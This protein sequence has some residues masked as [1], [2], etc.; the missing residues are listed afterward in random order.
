M[1]IFLNS[2][3]IMRQAAAA[4]AADTQRD[5]VQELVEVPVTQMMQQS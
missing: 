5:L 2:I 3:T 4:A 1:A